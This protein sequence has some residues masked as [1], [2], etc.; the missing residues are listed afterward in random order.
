MPNGHETGTATAREWEPVNYDFL[1][2]LMGK[3]LWP[4]LRGKTELHLGYLLGGCGNDDCCVEPTVMHR[5]HKGSKLTSTEVLEH[6]TSK[7]LRMAQ[8]GH[9]VFLDL[10]A[11]RCGPDCPLVSLEDGTLKDG[12]PKPPCPPYTG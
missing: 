3:H 7:H 2:H 8:S 4:R 11:S 1:V 6:F 12:C 10:L 9:S 5:E